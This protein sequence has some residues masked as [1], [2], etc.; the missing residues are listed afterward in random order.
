MASHVGVDHELFPR[1]ASV[2]CEAKFVD[3]GGGW[4]LEK[5]RVKVKKDLQNLLVRNIGNHLGTTVSGTSDALRTL[6]ALD[7]SSNQ[8]N[9][10]HRAL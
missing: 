4:S 3:D 6:N 1:V 9:L 8:S 5:Y 7:H 10:D 2:Y